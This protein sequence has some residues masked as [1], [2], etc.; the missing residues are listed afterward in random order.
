[1]PA[2]E[3][4]STA[5][6]IRLF[7]PDVLN[8]INVRDTKRNPMALPQVKLDVH[9]IEIK[10][11]ALRSFG[12]NWAPGSVPSGAKGSAGAGLLSGLSDAATSLIG[13]VFDLAPKI[14]F[15]RQKGDARVLENPSLVV[16]SGDAA[17]FFS[18]TQVPFYSQESVIFKD[19][20]IKIQAEPIV[21]SDSVDM[22]IN[23]TVTSPSAGGINRGIDTNTISTTAYCKAGQSLALGGIYRN[24]DAR[25]YNRIPDDT[26][27]GSALFTLFLSKDFVSDKSEFVIFVTPSVV[28]F[29]SQSGFA[30]ANPTGLSL[31]NWDETD[32]DITRQRSKKEARQ[33]KERAVEF[34]LPDSL[35]PKEGELR[36]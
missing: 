18:G 34:D 2:V 25:M 6:P 13:F 26:N 11:S 31:S 5:L 23:I 29:S 20:G 9:F 14:R 4:F 3:L 22:K 1:M 10:K 8:L 36:K 16:K 24:T 15:A 32:R 35:K 30:G 27:T 19:V 17:D 7:E 21:S 33:R 28:D 12:I